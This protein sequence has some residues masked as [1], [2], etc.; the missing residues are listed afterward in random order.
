MDTFDHVYS[1]FIKAAPDRVWRAITEGDETV[2]YYYGTRVASDWM[3]APL[4]Y[5]YPDGSLA[6]D[7]TVVEVEPGR[8]IVMSFHPRWDPEMEAEGPDPDD[9]AGRTGRRGWVEAHRDQRAATELEVGGVVRRRHRLHRVWSQDGH[10]DGGAARR[11]LTCA[12]RRRSPSPPP[13]PNRFTSSDRG[14]A[15]A[16]VQS[17]G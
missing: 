7:G 15:P 16:T 8:R 12:R 10:R 14:P 6:A 5:A 13:S 11:R 17:S 9:L 4:T 2:R 3:G 1:V